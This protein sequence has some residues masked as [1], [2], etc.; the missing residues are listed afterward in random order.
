[1]PPVAISLRIFDTIGYLN[2]NNTGQ[3]AVVELRS[4]IFTGEYTEFTLY[5]T[6]PPSSIIQAVNGKSVISGNALP[7]W[8]DIPSNRSLMV[9]MQGG[10]M[11][12]NTS[13][14][15]LTPYTEQASPWPSHYR[16][17]SHSSAL[18]LLFFYS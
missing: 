17:L 1:M 5:Y 15:Y 11:L 4:R 14:Q 8:C 9:T 7:D 16:P 12:A 3:S 6:V 2:F 18:S 10:A 13:F